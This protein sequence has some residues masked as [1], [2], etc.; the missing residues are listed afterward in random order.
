M[1]AD[2]IFNAYVQPGRGTETVQNWIDHLS[3]E[4]Y[5]ELEHTLSFLRVISIDKWRKPNGKRLDD[6][7]SEIMFDADRTGYRIRRKS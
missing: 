4:T 2:W 6:G 5:K 3:D 7:L 1:E